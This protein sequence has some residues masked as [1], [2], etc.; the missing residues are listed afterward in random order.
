MLLPGPMGEE[1]HFHGWE[2]PEKVKI[3]RIFKQDPPIAMGGGGAKGN[4]LVGTTYQ[5][6]HFELLLGQAAS[7]E[8]IEAEAVRFT[9]AGGGRGARFCTLPEELLAVNSNWWVGVGG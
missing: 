1:L 9:V 3:G 4:A 6:R 8:E 5:V 2:H 7:P